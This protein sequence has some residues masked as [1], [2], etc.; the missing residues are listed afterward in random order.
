MMFDNSFRSLLMIS[1]GKC[2]MCW[3]AYTILLCV[4][5]KANPLQRL[6]FYAFVELMNYEKLFI[7]MDKWNK[8]CNVKQSVSEPSQNPSS[9][10]VKRLQGR[11][12]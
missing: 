9:D 2:N 1:K 10:T 12:I 3:K 5:N 4:T 8:L 11:D 7:K 6:Y